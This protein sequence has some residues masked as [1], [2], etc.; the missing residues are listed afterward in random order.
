MSM[1]RSTETPSNPP[2][3]AA[4]PPSGGVEVRLTKVSK[5]FVPPRGQP[6][7]ALE[8]VDLMIEAGQFVSVL[9]PSGCGK[10]TLMSIVA[11]L[12]DATSGAV[13]IDGS[14]IDGPYTP[15]GVVFQRDLL[16][17]WRTCLDNILLQFEMR[18][19]KSK[20]YRDR[21]FELL[22]MV[23]IRDFHRRYPRELSGGMRQRVSI[24][25]AL[26]HD[27]GLLLMDEP[28]GALDALTREQLNDD[29]ADICA[30]TSKTVIF[31]THSIAEA[32]FLADRVVVMSA[33]PGR[34]V[35]DFDIDLP[36]PRLAETRTT[37]QFSAMTRKVRVALLDEGVL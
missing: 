17:E 32:V 1:S 28:F 2:L 37:D 14:L 19:L 29:L 33:R 5:T 24:C 4:A 6:V 30:K 35:A 12:E 20:P 15:A 10:S 13:Q 27:P 11:G 25:R 9:G 26:A 36:R 31:I 16:L 3:T 7:E 8:P 23:G 22:D 34:I 18:G 21:A